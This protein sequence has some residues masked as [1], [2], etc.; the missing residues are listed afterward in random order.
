MI[1]SAMTAAM[2]GARNRLARR[3]PP[4]QLRSFHLRACLGGLPVV[5]AVESGESLTVKHIAGHGSGQHRSR[6]AQ[7]PSKA[8]LREW[9]G[10]R[11]TARGG[12]NPPEVM[13]G[14]P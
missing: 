3:E 5:K 9:V 14:P 6:T 2:V 8:A 11:G 13:G 1:V 10:S 7:T 12:R 4:R